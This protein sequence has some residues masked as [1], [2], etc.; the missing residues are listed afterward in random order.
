MG[1]GA[2]SRS[3][4]KRLGWGGMPSLASYQVLSPPYHTPNAL[5]R[6]QDERV[7]AWTTFLLLSNNMNE[8]VHANSCHHLPHPNP[9]ELT[10]FL[11]TTVPAVG[12]PA[13]PNPASLMILGRPKK[14]KDARLAP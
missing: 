5:L 7:R 4:Y 8:K 2:H 9:H 3:V 11:L 12:P 10:F 1:G 6:C 13:S 14:L